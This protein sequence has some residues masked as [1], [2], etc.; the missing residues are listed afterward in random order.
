MSVRQGNIT[1]LCSD[2]TDS[3]DVIPPNEIVTLTGIVTEAI[4][5]AVEGKPE[6]GYT[7][8]LA[9]LQRAVEIAAEGVEW[10]PELVQR[11]RIASRT[12]PIFRCSSPRYWLNAVPK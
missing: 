2:Q 10:G 1:T 6:D 11:W 8:M 9:G 5:L 12:S 4:E 3:G 7:T